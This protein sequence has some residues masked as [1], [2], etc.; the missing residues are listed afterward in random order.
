MTQDTYQVRGMHCAS[1][2]AIITRT[3][4]KLPGV[5]KIDVNVAT[6]KANIQFDPAVTTLET[7]N[8][9]IGKLGYELQ[10]EGEESPRN[11]Q[12]AGEE[13]DKETL[14]QTAKV[15]FIVPV[16]G[17]VFAIMMWDIAARV[18]SSVPN[19]PL[20]MDLFNLIAFAL[21]TIT[22]F[23]VGQPFLLG[24]VRF[25]RYGAANMDTL[26]GI[27]TGVAYLYSS[28]VTLFPEV[29][30]WLR[31]PGDTYFDVVIVVIGFVTLGKYLEARAKAKTGAAIEKLL[32]L[33]AKVAL[34]VRDGHETEVPLDQVITGDM[35]RV[36]PGEKIPVDGT[37]LEGQSKVDESMLTGEPMPVGKSAGDKVTGGT[38][39]QSGTLL[40][41]AT[42]VGEA[43]LLAHIIRMVEEAEGSK[44]P[45]QKLADQVSA[46]FVPTVM[47]IA[48][49]ALIMWIFVGGIYFPFSEALTFGLTSFVGILVIACPCALG[50]ATPTAII[51]GVGK[52]AL[53]GILIKNASVLEKL[54][55]VNT[56]VI[57]KTGTLTVGKPTF[58]GMKSSAAGYDETRILTLLASLE[59]FSEHPIAHAIK[60]RALE[61]KISLLPI[62]DFE[63]LPGRG[64][65]ARV[66]DKHYWIGN[67]TLATERKITLDVTLLK[68]FS[69]SGGTPLL[70]MDEHTLLAVAGVGDQVKETAKQ[71]LSKLQKL[72]I[73]VVMATGDD[74]ETA[75]FIGQQVGITRIEAGVLPEGKKLLVQSLQKAGRVVAMAGDGVND[76]PALAQADVSLAMSTGT[77]VAIE[78]AD[79]TLLHGDIKK[80]EEA[81]LLSRATMRTIKQ[82]LFFAFVYN[83][84]G[85]PLAAGAFYPF[86][87]WL[88]SPV[89]AGFAMAASSVSVV[90]NSLRLKFARL[91]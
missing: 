80:I 50:L 63:A 68:Q 44:A 78:T 15:Q 72:G 74:S 90:S 60:E 58:L 71:A 59:Q 12:R 36:K 29:Q 1:C 88:L 82:N 48:V 40:F 65:S 3:L 54:H 49:G 89:F 30:A 28:I 19:L 35:I 57:D 45:I 84:I 73:E 32:T 7:M 27:G 87:G 11:K 22:L 25:V 24:V 51:V 14:S 16:A 69:G 31:V 18:F 75:H 52:G 79:M 53:R 86:T 39:N 43:T 13:R 83:V 81:I 61:K 66:G 26:I 8:Q 4:Q 76:A 85:I 20:P 56:L 70:L 9:A 64:L 2:S 17:L 34:V 38:V 5:E 47:V 62:T 77:D 41:R 37:I 67:A 46:V 23:W 33:Q 10:R 91:G 42:A 55:K 6:E 21:A